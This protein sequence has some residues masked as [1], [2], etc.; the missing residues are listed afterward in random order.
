MA[1]FDYL[2]PLIN[3]IFAYI[4]ILTAILIYTRN[5][6][7][8]LHRLISLLMFF[9]FGNFLFFYFK[10]I[11]ANAHY[12][13]YYMCLSDAC[14][15]FCLAIFFHITLYFCGQL[16]NKPKYAFLLIYTL[17]CLGIIAFLNGFL[18]YS[19]ATETSLGLFLNPSRYYYLFYCI[20]Y[21]YVVASIVLIIFSYKNI[22]ND[23]QKKRQLVFLALAIVLPTL[24]DVSTEF[25]SLDESAFFSVST[26]Y[27]P[28]YFLTT[29]LFLIGTLKYNVFPKYPDAAVGNILSYFP[30][31]LIV[32][33]GQGK[34]N[35]VNNSFLLLLD[36]KDAA[37]VIGHPLAEVLGSD[38][39]AQEIIRF[40]I[41]ENTPLHDYQIKL[42]GKTL[43]LHV[44]RIKDKT[45]AIVGMIITG[46]DIT[47]LVLNE[48]ELKNKT[49]ALEEKLSEIDTVNRRLLRREI[50]MVELKTA[51][52]SL[53]L[54]SSLG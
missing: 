5:P 26:I 32:T 12:A 53:K 46:S 38:F 21:T 49:L 23:P 40:V 10:V 45:A 50:E 36:K 41:K 15:Y 48:E 25:L 17:P 13:I 7:D 22:T 9:T 16:N 27:N 20:I 6:Y 18:P 11:S 19:T 31:L 28:L 43:G 24:L 47:D 35:M 2:Y 4:S 29:L 44:N 14:W 3:L 34:I 1:P 33:D 30:D 37:E 54:R 8:R 42:K 51:I 52:R 39:I